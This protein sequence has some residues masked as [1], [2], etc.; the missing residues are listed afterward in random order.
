MP[1]TDYILVY[2]KGKLDPSHVVFRAAVANAAKPKKAL[3]KM[4]DEVIQNGFGSTK[5]VAIQ[6]FIQRNKSNV[7][8][9]IFDLEN[10]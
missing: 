8:E 4:G 1:K 2:S 5:E 10:V 3:L 6:D 9:R 7:I